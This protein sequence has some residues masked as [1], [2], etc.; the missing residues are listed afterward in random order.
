[1]PQNGE[2]AAEHHIA[3]ITRQLVWD[4]ML[5]AARMHRYADAMERKYAKQRHW[6][7]IMLSLA[8]SGGIVTLGGFERPL[9]CPR[10][11]VDAEHAPGGLAEPPANPGALRRSAGAVGSLAGLPARHPPVVG[12]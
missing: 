5:D 3:P 4:N 7:R 12:I 8:A 9:R 11:L 6:V 1:M 2:N 10:R